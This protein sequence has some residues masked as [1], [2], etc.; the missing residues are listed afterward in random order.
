[1][2]G[3][4]PCLSAPSPTPSPGAALL[5]DGRASSNLPRPGLG[6]PIHVPLFPAQEGNPEMG[7]LPPLL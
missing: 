7:L 5:P 4:F 6:P 2:Q 3:A 1:M